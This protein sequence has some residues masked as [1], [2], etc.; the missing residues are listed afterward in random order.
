MQV[1]PDV[2]II[3]IIIVVVFLFTKELGLYLQFFWKSY[4]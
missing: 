3:I 4:K 2:I 1:F